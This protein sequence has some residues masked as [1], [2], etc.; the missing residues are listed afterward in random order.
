MPNPLSSVTFTPDTDGTVLCTA[1]FSVQQT[2][3]TSDWGGGDPGTKM[4]VVRVSDSTLL[5]T[6]AFQ[7][8]TRT[9]A[10]TSY[11]ASFPVYLADGA[12]T[13]GLHG[14]GGATGTAINVWDLD[15]VVEFIKR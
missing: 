7:P 6:G 5:Q 12:I 8:C 2:G 13:V 15:L 1:T 10:A 3:T 4:K 9:R 14:V 11:K